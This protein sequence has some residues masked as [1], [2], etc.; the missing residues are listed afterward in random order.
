M[1]ITF[2]A[3]STTTD[4]EVHRATGWLQGELSEK[5]IQQ[6]KD[7]PKLSKDNS[8]VVVY[9]SDLKRAIESAKLG[10]SKTHEL[11]TDWR[12][13]EANYGDFDG[14]NKSFKKDMT[15]FIDTPYPGGESYRDTEDRVREFI[16]DMKNEFDDKHIAIIGHEATQLALEVVLLGKTW[17]QVIDEN[18]RPSGAW[19]PG[20]LYV[21]N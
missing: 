19:Q 16:G 21:I 11:R 2:F 18:W 1:K 7:L 15:Q 20:W 4:N 12:L 8:F 3:H 14:Q 10:F 13:R 17:Q 5:G 9:S 6:A